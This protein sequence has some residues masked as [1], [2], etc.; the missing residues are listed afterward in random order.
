MK[1]LPSTERDLIER[2]RQ[3]DEAAFAALVE[4]YAATVYRIIHRMMPDRMEA[5]AI[6]QETF[7]RFWRALPG[8]SAEAP[9][10]P[11]LATIASNLARDRFR[12]ERR[13]EDLP[14]EDILDVREEADARELES[15]VEDE[16]TRERLAA[17]VRSLPPAYR[18]VI[19]L[20]YE[21]D[22]SYEQ[23]AEALSLPV[24]TVRT[25]LRRAKDLLRRGLEERE[26]G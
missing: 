3:H 20:R 9:L 7:W 23:I 16:R 24:N 17:C 18:M 26:D 22:M 8:Y 15:L 14:A 12:R 1:P 5:E 11:Y 10:L 4:Q 6:V 2:A 19:S 21:A 13:L 25:H